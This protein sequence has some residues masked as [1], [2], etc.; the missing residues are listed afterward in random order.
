MTVRSVILYIALCM[1]APCPARKATAAEYRQQSGIIG[2][3]GSYVIR[4]DDSLIELA[5]T[6]GLGFNEIVA[7]N[8]GVDP[9][10][11][12]PGTRILIPSERIIPDIPRRIG[13]VVNLQE[14]RLYHFHPHNPDR[15]L[16]FPIG[17]GDE[18]WETP[19]GTYRVVEKIV[20][21]S[22][23][24]PRS[25]RRQRHDLPGV[26]PPGPHNPL[27]THALRLSAGNVLIHG[28]NRPFGIGRKVSHGC[29]RLYPE[30]IPTLFRKTRVGARVTIVRQ[31][32]KATVVAGRVLVELHGAPEENLY[33]RAFALLLQ[34][35]L[36][37]KVDVEKL[38]TA[39]M[40]KRG[41]PT[42]VS[43]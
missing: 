24:V 19:T 27:G 36:L 15:V 10:L 5:R 2:S 38:L 34:K 29:I 16:T 28:T 30:D 35:G 1:F 23:H 40:E 39:A 32:V 33:G 31:P 26:V 43:W 3:S 18:G 11:P 21:P 25:I 42:D 13:I 20:N 12:E 41:V 6:F 37:E 22:W 7:A 14:M 8:P 9:V 17:I 4:P